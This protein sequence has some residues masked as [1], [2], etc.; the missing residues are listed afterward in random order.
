[1]HAS[2]KTLTLLA[3][4]ATSA[5]ATVFKLKTHVT[6]FD[7][8]PSLEGQE[9]TVA[10]DTGFAYLVAP[11][12]GATFHSNT[13]VETDVTGEPFF[14]HVTPGGTATVPSTN[15]VTFSTAAGTEG[16]GL[17]DGKLAYENGAFTA[18]PA[19]VLQREGSDIL[20]SFKSAGQ[21]TLAGCAN[22]D[23]QEA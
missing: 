18:C 20:I 12:S 21:R 3:I 6:D 1:M 15:V 17:V 10:D 19:S 23:L 8:T 9:V 7:L 4:A 14:I 22:V 5:S 2:L 13:T 16:V 11:G